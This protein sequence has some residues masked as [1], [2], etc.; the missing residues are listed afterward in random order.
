MLK[1]N[2][3]KVR[4]KANELY[5]KKLSKRKIIQYLGSSM[6]FVISWTKQPNQDPAPDQRGWKKGK[7][8]KYTEF[9]ITNGTTSRSMSCSL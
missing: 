4:R 2:L 3:I 7:P 5:F 6:E 1:T 9:P 8:R